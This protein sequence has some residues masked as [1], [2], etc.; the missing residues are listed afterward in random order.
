MKGRRDELARKKHL[1]YQF[2]MAKYIC[3]T[4]FSCLFHR[5][6]DPKKFF[7]CTNQFYPGDFPFWRIFFSFFARLC[8]LTFSPWKYP[9]LLFGK[10]EI[11]YLT[12]KLNVCYDHE[13][14]PEKKGIKKYTRRQKFHLTRTSRGLTANIRGSLILF[15]FLFLLLTVNVYASK[16]AINDVCSFLRAQN[17]RHNKI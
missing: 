6:S 2:I 5:V 8:T 1:F 10:E 4:L 16:P 12:L 3:F 11:T 13:W 7:W 14:Q 17:K 9:P 15:L